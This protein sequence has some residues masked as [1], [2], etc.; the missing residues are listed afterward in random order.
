MQTLL[1]KHLQKTETKPVDLKIEEVITCT[2]F[3]SKKRL[4]SF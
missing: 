1:Y 2:S 4:E 3:G